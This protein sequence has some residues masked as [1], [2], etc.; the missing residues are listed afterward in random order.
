MSF[1]S[2]EP[3]FT[4]IIPS[5]N[6]AEYLVH[7][8][9]SCSI[10]EYP[11]LEIIVSDDGSTDN[12]KDIVLQAASLD[13]R[14]R[15]ISPPASG[16]RENFEF[17]LSQ[18]RPGFVIALGGDDG[19]LPNGIRDMNELIQRTGAE[20]LAWPA[21]VFYYS[22]VKSDR[23]QLILHA[24]AGR[25]RAGHKIL[26]TDEFLARTANELSYVSDVESP[27]FYVKGVVSTE[28]IDRVR[29]RSPDGRFYSCST[30]D[31]YSGIVIACELEQY[32]F[33]EV[34][35]SI[36][37][38]SPSSFGLGYLSESESAKKQSA[39]FFRDAEK[40]PMHAELG[41]Q[42]YS[43]LICLMTADYLLTAKD[44]PGWSSRIPDIDFEKLVKQSLN[45][46]ADGNYAKGRVSRE[47]E[48]ISEVAR[49]RKL[50]QVFRKTLKKVR[51][52]RRQQ[53]SGNAIS[54]SRLYLDGGER[55]IENIVEAAYLAY[56]FHSFGPKIKAKSFYKM[57]LNSF[58]YY[59]Q[60]LRK[61]GVLTA[62]DFS[63]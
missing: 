49:Y 21:P 56:F 32:V 9:R 27:M 45:E 23:S 29:S 40:I 59:L 54:L 41:G 63:M 42:P 5:K 7:T 52:N 1:E 47:L 33:S 38:M 28:V 10:Q 24:R 2:D 4:V 25:A 3:L 48:I 55:A 37:G 50:D 11:N 62:D 61:S 13:P 18:V 60:S 34:P 14:I 30:P 51:R 15:Y 35:F 26:S 19:L 44:L 8:L 43:P 46:L 57:L 17:A 12:T 36:Y 16:M 53:L 39:E 20:S 31:G 58:R 6:R 22:N